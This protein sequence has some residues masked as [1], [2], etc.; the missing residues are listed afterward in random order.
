MATDY[1]SREAVLALKQTPGAYG[2]DIDSREV[3]KIPAAD[4][5]PVVFCLDCINNEGGFCDIMD[6][7]SVNDDW[8]CAAGIRK[9]DADEAEWIPTM[10]AGYCYPWYKCSKCGAKVRYEKK[11]CGNCGRKMR[12][13]KD[14]V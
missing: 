12:R 2:M 13:S 11:Y 10:E 9:I 7:Q 5:R 14:N 4:V 1:I 6:G 8:F 3:E